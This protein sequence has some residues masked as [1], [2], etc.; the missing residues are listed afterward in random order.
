MLGEVGDL[1]DVGAVVLAVGKRLSDRV[2]AHCPAVGSV[3][4]D[5][6]GRGHGSGCLHEAV[7]VTEDGGHAEHP[8]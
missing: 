3:V 7:A 2:G 1:T 6:G 8:R 5:D 4:V